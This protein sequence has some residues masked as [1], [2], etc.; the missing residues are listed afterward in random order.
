LNR[1][2][3]ALLGFRAS[4]AG[5]T[6]ALSV[7]PQRFDLSF[8]WFGD[9][10]PDED[11]QQHIRFGFAPFAER[12]P[13]PYFYLA[14]WPIRSE[15]V[16]EPLPDGVRWHTEGWTGAVFDYDAVAIEENPEATIQALLTEIY[17]T[18]TRAM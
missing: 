8:L 16:Y 15:L 4:L 10:L 7:W 9:N 5:E 11:S 2:A 17:E 12:Y 6:T 14:P 13:R 18:I 3:G 1:I